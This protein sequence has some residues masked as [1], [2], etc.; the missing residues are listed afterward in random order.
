MRRIRLFINNCE[1]YTNEYYVGFDASGDSIEIYLTLNPK[2]KKN[3]QKA[4]DCLT[5]LCKKTKLPKTAF[6]LTKFSSG[7]FPSC[8]LSMTSS[9]D[10]E[11]SNKT[12]VT[13]IKNVSRFYMYHTPECN[14]EGQSNKIE[15]SIHHPIAEKAMELHFVEGFTI[16][17]DKIGIELKVGPDSTPED[18]QTILLNIAE[19]TKQEVSRFY[20]INNG[21][22]K[23]DT[24][25]PNEHVK[26]NLD[27][28]RS[29]SFVSG[30]TEENGTITV[31]CDCDPI[32]DFYKINTYLQYMTMA[33]NEPASV[34][35]IKNISE[36]P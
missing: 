33:T 32:D 12:E 17:G 5:E 25:T 6:R 15:R 29:L 3:H 8:A 11:A 9:S 4:A 10:D 28:L 13:D 18:A 26:I 27:P 35:C 30:Y 21:G 31:Y 34:F 23:R 20:L 36:M 24:N 22:S 2:K 19:H 7:L 16:T 1:K 14:S